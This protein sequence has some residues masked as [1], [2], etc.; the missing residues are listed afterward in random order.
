MPAKIRDGEI[1]QP[2]KSYAAPLC[3]LIASAFLFW[4][5]LH[6]DDAGLLAGLIFLFSAGV[7]FIFGRAGFYSAPLIGWSIVASELWELR[8]GLEHTHMTAKPDFLWLL[9]F[10]TVVSILGG[11]FGIGLRRLL[12][13]N[14]PDAFQK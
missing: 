11:L 12:A 2:M 6:S 9:F 1:I 13:G 10:V 14:L 7:A 8:L 3:A 4:G 5:N